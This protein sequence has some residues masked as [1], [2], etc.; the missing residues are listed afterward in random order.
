MPFMLCQYNYKKECTKHATKEK[1][2]VCCIIEKAMELHPYKVLGYPETYNSYNEGWTDAL[3]Y[4]LPI[5]DG[6]ITNMYRGE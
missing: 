5:F 3:E 2:C 4:L 6:R 1:E